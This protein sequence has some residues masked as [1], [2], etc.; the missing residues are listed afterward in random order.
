MTNQEIFNVVSRGMLGTLRKSTTT[1]Y[2][3]NTTCNAYIGDDGN[4]C[5]LGMLIPPHIGISK[6]LNTLRIIQP[7]TIEFFTRHNII[8]KEQSYLCTTTMC[9]LAKLQAAHD[10]YYVLDW[11]D[12]LVRIAQE[13]D[14][15]PPQQVVPSSDTLAICHSIN[16]VKHVSLPN[17]H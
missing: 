3:H 9:L 2:K 14:L 5:G 1:H 10:F 4:R 16:V 12:I 15:N 11:Y 13:F 6:S 7:E 17:L 8:S